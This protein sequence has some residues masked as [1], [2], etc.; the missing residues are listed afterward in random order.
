MSLDPALSGL[1]LEE[2]LVWQRMS[3]SGGCLWIMWHV[4]GCLRWQ[5]QAVCSRFPSYVI[6]LELSVPAGAVTATWTT[7][8]RTFVR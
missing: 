3:E 5:R 4:A 1:Q 2:G 7:S 8:V 6:D